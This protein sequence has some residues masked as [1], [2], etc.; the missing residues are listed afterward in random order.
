[1]A[2]SIK[3]LILVSLTCIFSLL[4]S[5]A[6]AACTI[7]SEIISADCS[8]TT[9]WST[10]NIT[11]NSGVTVSDYIFNNSAV[12]TFVNNG[13]LFGSLMALYNVDGGAITE[14]INNGT[15]GSTA[16]NKLAI[17]NVF[18]SRIT[19]LTNN[20]TLLGGQSILWRNF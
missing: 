5:H 16:S 12:G 13:I 20:G 10:G 7:T 4:S 11:I 3:K 6:M 15:I 9:T 18:D 8:G 17:Y 2:S 19:K 14:I 1:M